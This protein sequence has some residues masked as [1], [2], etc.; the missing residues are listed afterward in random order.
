MLMEN[1]DIK[2][3]ADRIYAEY[4]HLFPSLYP[5]IPLITPKI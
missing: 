1:K 5:D 3:L 2:A 4:S